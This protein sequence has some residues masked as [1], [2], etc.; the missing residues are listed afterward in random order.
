MMT[1]KHGLEEKKPLWQRLG[2]LV[3]IWAMSVA[4]LG[5]IGD[6][7]LDPL[8]RFEAG[9]GFAFPFDAAVT[10][11]YQAHQAAQQ[12]GLAHAIAAQQAGDFA[13]LGFEGQATQDVA[14]AVVLVQ[15]VDLEHVS[16]PERVTVP[17]L[18]LS[19]ACGSWLAGDR[20]GTGFN[21]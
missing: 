20:A 10:G 6:T 14:A 3:L 21:V 12:G 11:G 7:G 13:D 17:V 5:Y 15:G 4:A 8:L 18:A 1:G 9:D 2:W 19:R 16:V